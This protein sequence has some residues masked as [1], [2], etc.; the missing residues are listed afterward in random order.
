[1]IKS[2]KHKGL[3][4]LAEE[5]CP[6]GVNPEHTGKLNIFLTALQAA[7]GPNDLRFP[8]SWKLHPLKGEFEGYWSLTV[9]KNWRL[10]FK[11]D[12]PDVILLDYLDYH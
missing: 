12:G 7:T 4:K 2:I 5:G 10:I 9:T 8:P 6:S 3:K 11:F 1:M